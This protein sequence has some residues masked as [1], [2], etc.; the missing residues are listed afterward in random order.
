MTTTSHSSDDEDDIITEEEDLDFFPINKQEARALLNE[1]KNSYIDY[2][3]ELARTLIRQ[4]SDFVGID[5][6]TTPPKV[7]RDCVILPKK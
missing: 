4:L 1:C 5:E 3:N 2:D 6:Y 7:Y